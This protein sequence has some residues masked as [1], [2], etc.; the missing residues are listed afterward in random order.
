VAFNRLNRQMMKDG[1]VC[2]RSQRLRCFFAMGSGIAEF[3]GWPFQLAPQNSDVPRRVE[4]DGNPIPGDPAD[5]QD[6]VIPDVNPFA[7]FSTEH[8]HD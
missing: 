7:Y 5:L 6:D 1:D 4:R 2:G 3:A 8:Q